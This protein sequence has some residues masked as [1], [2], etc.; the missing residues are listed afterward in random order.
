MREKEYE[1]NRNKA[2]DPSIL[3]VSN[4]RFFS[5]KNVEKEK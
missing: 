3:F 1:H 4:T 5:D 2:K